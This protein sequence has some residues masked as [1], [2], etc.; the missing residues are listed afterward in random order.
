[1]KLKHVNSLKG[2]GTIKDDDSYS[3]RPFID[4][5]KFM[6]NVL[7]MLVLFCYITANNYLNVQGF[8]L[9]EYPIGKMSPN[10]YCCRFIECN[11]LDGATNWDNVSKL[12][13][14]FQTTQESCYR[15][16]GSVLHYYFKYMQWGIGGENGIPYNDIIPFIKWLLFGLA[17]LF[18][19]GMMLGFVGLIFIPGWFGG[20]VAYRNLN[21]RGWW[22]IVSAL[23]TLCFGWVSIFPVIYEFFHL[24]YLFFFKQ[25]VLA[26]KSDN[27][28]NKLSEEFTKR[29][30]K[31]IMVFVIVAVIV[32]AMQLPALSA[33]VIGGIVL[34]AAMWFMKNKSTTKSA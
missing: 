13:W 11:N 33:C 8:K 28:S 27:S 18:S 1:M 5:L 30:S 19:I 20:L 34:L 17:T 25:L 21:A 3:S 16:M 6:L 22:Y 31:W 29:M 2:T 7:I 15:S 10:P 26:G 23:L 4:Y 14:W 12:P 9:D 32:A 24:I